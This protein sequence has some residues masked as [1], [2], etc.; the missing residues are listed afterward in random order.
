MADGGLVPAKRRCRAISAIKWPKP[1]PSAKPKSWP[2]PSPPRL[3]HELPLSP[4]PLLIPLQP[5]WLDRVV[6]V[7]AAAYT[8]PWTPGNFRDAWPRATRPRCWYRAIGCWAIT[9]PCRCSTR[10]IC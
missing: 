2:P 1:R 3:L 10:C 8:H 4:A 7:E 6:A 9:W 5:E